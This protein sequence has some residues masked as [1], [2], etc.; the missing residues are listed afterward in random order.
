MSEDDAADQKRNHCMM[1]GDKSRADNDQRSKLRKRVTV[2]QSC[3][4]MEEE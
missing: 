1:S 3:M 4:M 2:D